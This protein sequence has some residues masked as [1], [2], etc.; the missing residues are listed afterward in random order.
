M[1]L[2]SFP[3]K[4]TRKRKISNATLMKKQ[5]EIRAEIVQENVQCDLCGKEFY[6]KQRNVLQSHKN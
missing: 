3:S 4:F 1:Q 6:F 2:Q 5:F